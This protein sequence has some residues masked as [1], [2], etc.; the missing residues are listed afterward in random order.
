MDINRQDP[1][2]GQPSGQAPSVSTEDARKHF[3]GN[4]SSNL[5]Y[6]LWNIGTS[7]FMVPYQIRNLGLANYGM[8]TLALSFTMYTQVLTIVLTTTL[9]RFVVIHVA[10]GDMREARAYFNTQLIATAWFVALF[11]PISSVVSYYTPGFLRIPP[12][13]EWNTRILFAAMYLSLLV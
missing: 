9:F 10:R 2:S 6:F 8:V 5:L 12:G 7:F 3:L 1:S 13:Q 11:L 4:A